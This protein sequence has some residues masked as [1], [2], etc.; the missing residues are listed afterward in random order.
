MCC[1]C[2]ERICMYMYVDV[3]AYVPYSTG[4]DRQDRQ[5]RI[6]GQVAPSVTLS[7]S[8]SSSHF[9][10]PP[11]LALLLSLTLSLSSHSHSFFLSHS[12]SHSL[13]PTAHS[14]P[15]T[16][17]LPL[18]LSHSLPL[19]LP[20]PLT[21]T[22]SLT[23]SLSHSL[24]LSL[25]PPTS[26]VTTSLTIVNTRRLRRALNLVLSTK[27][28]VTTSRVP[29]HRLHATPTHSSTRLGPTS[30]SIL[31]PPISHY[32]RWGIRSNHLPFPRRNQVKPSTPLPLRAF[33]MYLLPPRTFIRPPRCL[34][35]AEGDQA[36]KREASRVF[37]PSRETPSTH[38]HIHTS[39][40]PY[41][42]T[43]I[44]PYESPFYGVY[45]QTSKHR[46]TQTPRHPNIQTT[47]CAL[48]KDGGDSP[49]L[50]VSKRAVPGLPSRCDPPCDA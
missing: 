42:H 8:L 15:L 7:F 14:L 22:H 31:F 26:Q 40:H 25:S 11:T 19:P 36:L 44:H 49:L 39:T 29:F 30:S 47:R 24:T 4:Q 1:M 43:S 9:S 20:L 34:C 37:F 23:L 50:P 21:P 17:S 2:A 46:N 33:I 28:K 41:I 6:G 38:P 12:L 27:C 13:S 32:L 3:R 45:I 16:L 18:S 48:L 5:D 10:R 35:R